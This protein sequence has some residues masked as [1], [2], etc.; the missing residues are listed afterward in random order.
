ME[1]SGQRNKEEMEEMKFC[2]KVSMN[3]MKKTFLIGEHLLSVLPPG[4]PIQTRRG[5]EQLWEQKG[6][7]HLTLNGRKNRVCPWPKLFFVSGVAFY[8]L[9]ILGATD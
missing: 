7:K 4:T 6:F 2:T 5:K 3:T 1:E 8:L 9:S